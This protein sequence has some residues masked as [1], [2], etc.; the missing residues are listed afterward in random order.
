MIENSPSLLSQKE[1]WEM[2]NLRHS[3][4]N[5]QQ[6]EGER[7]SFD[8][9]AEIHARARRGEAKQTIAREVGVDRKTVRRRLTQERPL[10]YQRTV[11]RPALV[12]P[13]LAY[14]QHR[15]TE[16]DD[17]A[18]RIVQELKAQGDVGGY[19]MV[20]LAVRPLRAER[21]RLAEATLRFETAPGH[22]AQVDW[23]STWAAIDGQR[24]RVHRLGMVLD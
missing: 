15:V 12:R 2:D 11:S 20:K 19:E 16:V 23:G 22:Q 17:H 8:R 9:W 1:G 3:P 21:D 13:Y 4:P 18:A 6:G 10:R 24:V 7:L 14:I 5:W